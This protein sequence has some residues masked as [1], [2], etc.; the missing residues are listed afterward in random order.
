MSAAPRQRESGG[1]WWRL[2]GVGVMFVGGGGGQIVGVL[3][4]NVGD[5]AATRLTAHARGHGL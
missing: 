1:F 3:E 4:W 2:T 5:R